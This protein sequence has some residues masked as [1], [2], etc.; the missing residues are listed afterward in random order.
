[1]YGTQ[2]P[3]LDTVARLEPG[4]PREQALAELQQIASA[5]AR[6]VPDANGR[7]G[8]E[9]TRL[10]DDVSPQSRLLLWCLLAAAAGLLLIACTNVANLLLTHGLSR[11]KE[12]AVRAALGAGRHR[13]VRQM[14]TESLLLAGAG[15]IAGVAMASAALPAVARLVP[16]AL[17]IGEVPALD[18]RLLAAAT[19]ATAASAIGVGLLPALRV[20]RQADV[21]ALRDGARAGAGRRTERLRAALVVAQVAASVVLLVSSGLLLRAV[22]QLQRVDPGFSA[23][24]VLTLR[25]ALPVPKYDAVARRQAFFGRVLEE[26]QALPGVSRA[27]YI[28]GLPM[29]MRASIWV[30]RVPDQPEPPPERRTAS[31]RFVTPGFFATLGIPILAGRDVADGDTQTAPAVAVI[32]RSFAN[33]HWPAQ[34]PIGRVFRIQGRDRAVVGVVGDVRVRG[35]ERDSEP[36]AYLPAPQVADG[37]LV[38]YIPKDLAVKASVPPAALIPS[39]RAIVARADPQQPISD[40]QLLSDIVGAETG[41][42]R[43]Q[44]RVLG[45]FALVAFLLAGVGLHGLL[46]YHVSQRAREIGVRIALG[47]QRRSILGMVM[48]HGLVLAVVGVAIGGGLALA[49]GRL[50]ESLLAGISPTDP[51]SFGAA[52]GLALTMTFVGSLLPALRAVRLNPLDVMRPE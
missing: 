22:L 43:V 7:I 6:I 23:A 14:L 11:Q 25:T 50:I 9:V 47:A 3:Y 5:I 4:V 35:L 10:R 32:S 36:Q 18:L 1:V 42:R 52:V 20:A 49:A 26:V 24:G 17:P 45:G 51:V 31:L 46:A 29:I 12:L 27:A 15:G 16:T 40:I 48:R 21:S 44:V 34:D 13:L 37:A 28:S 30:V 38:G 19:V 33:R 39:I 2:N 41:P 8:V